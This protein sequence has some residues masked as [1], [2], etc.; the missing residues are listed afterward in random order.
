MANMGISLVSKQSIELELSTGLIT[1]LA[2]ADLPLPHK[3]YLVR[4]A[5]KYVSPLV[6]AFY[7][8]V[9]AHPSLG[10]IQQE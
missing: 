6:Q 8:F 1:T 10:H 4:H 7:H 2:F 5:N 9:Q 3:W